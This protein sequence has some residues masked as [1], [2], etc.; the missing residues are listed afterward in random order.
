MEFIDTKYFSELQKKIIL[1]KTN[2]IAYYDI[3]LSYKVTN[4]NES[5]LSHD[6]IKTCIKRS[7]L[8]LRWDKG[9]I[10]GKLPTIS[11]VDVDSLKDYI[12][13][14]ALQGEYIDVEDTVD[15]A[16]RLRTERIANARRFLIQ[17]KCFKILEEVTIYSMRQ[18][19]ARTWVYQHIDDLESELYTPR[20]IETNRLIACTPEKIIK[21]ADIFYQVLQGYDPPLIFGADETTLQPNTKKKIII[22]NFS[23]EQ[24]MPDETQMQHITAMCC[25]N[26]IGEKMPLYLILSNLHKLPNE[27]K[28]ISEMNQAFFASSPSG[29]ET[30]DT[31]TWF[32]ILFINY[33]SNYR[34]K[35]PPNI[36]NNPALLIV[37]GH[38][39]RENPLAIKLLREN[40]VNIFV[41]PAH[42]S[43]VTQMF[44]VGIAS[45][46][47]SCFTEEFHKLLKLFD[48]NLNHPGQLREFC[49]K[50]ALYAWDTKA[51]IKSCA[52]A[53]KMTSTYPFNKDVLIHNKFVG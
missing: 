2:G 16:E 15:E 7:S 27:L 35:L 52:N 45:P 14:N 8:S 49:V 41:L 17:I 4:K 5:N 53:A 48:P 13:D 3:S 23:Q 43:H 19:P 9:E 12:V 46:F 33:L 1:Q 11:P 44:D 37:D 22:P 21:F 38:K 28:F 26:C 29:W 50:A 18:E 31:F 34:L 24:L 25:A 20:N 47:K 51:N 6:A 42:T 40:N 39:S 36:R 32:A 10:S 30:R